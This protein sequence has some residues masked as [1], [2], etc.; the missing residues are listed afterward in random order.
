VLSGYF[1]AA[2]NIGIIIVAADNSTPTSDFI[3]FSMSRV[4]LSSDA[5]DDGEKGIIGTYSFTAELNGSGGALLADDQTIL[6]VQDSQ[7]S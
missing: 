7:A 6:T 5:K 1:D 3:S 2:T 4:K